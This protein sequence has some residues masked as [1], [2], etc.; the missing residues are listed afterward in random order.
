VCGTT[1]NTW[2]D[3]HP[4]YLGAAFLQYDCLVQR[5]VV[6][7]SSDNAGAAG[8]GAIYGLGIFGAFVYFWQQA[9]TFWEYVFSF[10]QGLFWPAFMV[11]E[12]FAALGG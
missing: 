2:C 10:F 9:D 11:Y 6:T 4:W 7:M 3:G 12:V 1:Q 8:G 5:E